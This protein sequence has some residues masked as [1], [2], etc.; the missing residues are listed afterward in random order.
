MTPAPGAT[1]APSTEARAGAPD[2]ELTT[3]LTRMVFAAPPERAWETLMFYEQLDERPPFYLRLLLPVPIR[4]EGR[5][6]EVGDEALCLYEGGHLVKRVTEVARGR[7]YGFDVV[8][9][10]LA[11]GGGMRLQGG[12]YTLAPV[13]DGA[14]TEMVAVTRYA[15]PRRPRWLW[16][17]VEAFVCHL[18]HRHILAA[19]RREAESR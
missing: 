5:K 13:A 4:T 2:A 7:H 19:M 14:G 15:S 18:F 17:R 10:K 11:V 3:V 9:Q 6:S 16:R 1:G 8:E 12:A